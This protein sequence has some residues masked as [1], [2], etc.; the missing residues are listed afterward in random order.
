MS[1][2]RQTPFYLL[3]SG[4]Q[5]LEEVGLFLFCHYRVREHLLCFAQE[6]R[7]VVHTGAVVPNQQLLCLGFAGNHSRL[8]CGGVHGQFALVGI[9]LGVGGLVKQ[10]VHAV[11]LLRDF[12]AV[13]GVGA[14]GVPLAGLLVAVMLSK[15][16]AACGHLVPQRNGLDSECAV[17]DDNLLFARVQGVENHL[18]GEVGAVVSEPRAQEFLQVG[19]RVDVQGLRAAEHAQRG[20]QSYQAETMV[21]VQVRNKHRVQAPRAHAQLPHSQLDAFAT[22]NEVRPPANLQNLPR[23]GVLKRGHRTAATQ[24]GEFC[25]I[26]RYAISLNSDRFAGIHSLC[27][28]G[29]H[30][31]E[32]SHSSP[33]HDGR[34][35]PRAALCICRN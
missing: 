22:I 28:A 16:E 35:P 2:A 25:L 33:C 17:V 4:A 30:P 18:I 29:S 21:A 6:L 19:V 31:A 12:L 24:Y 10:E 9:L 5:R 32:S 3:P 26:H 1:L 20:N 14:I 27:T 8:L 7:M 11:Y 34:H 23:G 15:E 13:H